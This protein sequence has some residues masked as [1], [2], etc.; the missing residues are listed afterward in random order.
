MRLFRI[1]ITYRNDVLFIIE[2][3]LNNSGKML[4]GKQTRTLIDWFELRS[5]DKTKTCALNVV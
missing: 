3:S 1:E 4:R 2:I 5:D